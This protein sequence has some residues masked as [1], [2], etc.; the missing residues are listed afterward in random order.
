MAAAGQIRLAVVSACGLYLN[1]PPP[2]PDPDELTGV[3]T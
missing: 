1:A 2:G 3:T